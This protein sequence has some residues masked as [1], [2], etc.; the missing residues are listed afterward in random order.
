MLIEQAHFLTFSQQEDPELNYQ[1]PM[2]INLPPHY[3]IRILSTG[4]VH[5]YLD[6]CIQTSKA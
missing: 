1:R 6:C 4:N 5:S 2:I 3:S